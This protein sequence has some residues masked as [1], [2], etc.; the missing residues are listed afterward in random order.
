MFDKLKEFNR[1]RL[2]LG[3]IILATIPCYCLGMVLLWNVNL[4]RAQKTAT[5]TKTQV[6]ATLEPIIPTYTQFFNTATIT[7]T[8]TVTYTFTPTITYGLPPT[9]T[10]MPSPT[11]TQTPTDTPVP[12]P[13]LTNTPVP[14][15]ITL[16]NQPTATIPTEVQ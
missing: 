5:P 6:G 14:P 13:S 1:T 15:T 2:I 12:L 16:I 7:S 10:L 4:E 11:S 9:R 8:P 3:I